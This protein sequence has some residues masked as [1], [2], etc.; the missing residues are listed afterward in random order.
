MLRA[1][2]TKAAISY[3]SYGKVI[4]MTD[5]MNNNLASPCGLYCGEC[6]YYEKQ[7]RG[8][9]AS[10]G[11]PLWGKCRT[12]ACVRERNAEHCGEC[13]EFPC[14]RFLKQYSR[15]LGSW[16][17]FYKAGQLLYRKKIGTTSWAKEKA[18]GKNPDPKVSVER[19]L[20]WEKTQKK[21]PKS[22]KLKSG[23]SSE[24]D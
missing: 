13:A 8:C 22:R 16:R 9:V 5:A 17:V 19:Y 1:R 2:E 23:T 21:E 4:S 11:R 3:V 15:E 18:S 12:Y 6:L 20:L 7:C 10:N 24:E 14:N